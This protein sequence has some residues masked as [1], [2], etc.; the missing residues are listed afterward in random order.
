VRLGE[1][2]G[3]GA[4][5]TAEGGAFHQAGAAGI[6]VEERTA[7]DFPGREQSADHVTAAVLDLGLF[8]DADAEARWKIHARHQP[9]EIELGTVPEHAAVLRLSGDPRDHVYLRRSVDSS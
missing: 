1:G 3:T 5:Q 7:G 6:I 4:R 9:G 8:G 2:G